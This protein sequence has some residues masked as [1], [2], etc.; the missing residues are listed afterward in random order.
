MT[1]QAK[2]LCTLAASGFAVL[3]L[4]APA[5]ALSNQECGAKYQAAKTAGTLNGQKYRDFQ[6]AECS[7]A[8]AEAPAAAPAAP[9]AAPAPAPAPAAAEAKPKKEKKEKD[10]APAAAPAAP[11]ATGNAVFPTVV[12]PK[13][14]SE[15]PF[16]QR[17][18]TCSVQWK[19]NK[20]NKTTGDMHWNPKGGGGFY[21]ECNR[22]LKGEG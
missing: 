11:V 1:I 8:A 7:A 22:R 2:L 18:H 9:A 12:D 10:A 4:A 13:Y 16:L 17:M 3:T 15:K 14:A 19:M 6:K 5:L 21:P 20:D